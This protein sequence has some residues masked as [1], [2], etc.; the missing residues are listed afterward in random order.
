M[1]DIHISIVSH[2]QCDLV[3][4]VLQDL[5]V[6][7]CVSRI[8]VTLTHNLL[9]KE[10]MALEGLP[11]PIQ[12]IQNDLPKGFGENHN[13]AFNLSE[14]A[15]ERRYFL[16]LNPDIHFTVDVIGELVAVLE[17][18]RSIGVIAPSVRNIEGTLEDSARQLP[19]LLG[20]MKKFFGYQGTY[21]FSSEQD[22]TPDWVAGMFMLF[23]SEVFRQL[24][25]FDTRYFL[26]YEDVDI[27]CRLWLEGYSVYVRP[28]LSIVHDARRQSRKNFKYMRWHLSSILRF[29]NSDVYRKVKVLHQQRYKH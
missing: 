14:N 28:S 2:A 18:D 20:L 9:Q 8:Y 10:S 5:R 29:L 7:D 16:V 12:V 21:T 25:G 6:L 4:K 15:N 13:E 1:R 11:F 24:G 26:Y 23:R 22:Y 3:K 19:T 17:S 27:C